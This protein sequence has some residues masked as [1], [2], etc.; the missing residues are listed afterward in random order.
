MSL[1]ANAATICLP[2]FQTVLRNAGYP[3]PA[4]EVKGV[5]GNTFRRYEKKYLLTAEQYEYLLPRL[6]G[7]MVF[8]E[9]CR[10]NGSYSVCTLYLDTPDG[11]IARRC[12]DFKQY[13][14]K[15]R[16]RSYGTPRSPEDR[17]FV[18]LKRKLLGEGNKRRA[19]L[20][21]CEAEGF[22]SGLSRPEGLSYGDRQ[23]LDEI[24]WFMRGHP[25]IAPAMYI[26]YER[27]AFA[28]RGDPGLRLTVDA[29]ILWRRDAL[30]LAAGSFGESL[31]AP[32]ERLMEIKIPGA[33]PLWLAK[34]LS[35]AEA[36]PAGFSKYGRAFLADAGAASREKT[37]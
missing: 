22:I 34:A 7:H 19:S 14:E 8:D 17:V 32:G 26:S 20:R 37:A 11:A 10:K 12:A 28:G 31:L 25:G 2:F 13:K 18:C 15:L 27:Q 4:S 33:M 3:V 16:L 23:V 6:E 30:S 1:S 36:F 29:D 5:G 35:R 24:E 9:Y 21:L